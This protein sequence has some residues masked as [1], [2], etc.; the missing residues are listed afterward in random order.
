MATIENNRGG[1]DDA[2]FSYS[3]RG[4]G[5]VFISW[6]GRQVKILRGNKAVSFLH[7]VAGL[8]SSDQQ[9]AMAK[10][11]GNFKRGNEHK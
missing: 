2:P 1:L 3:D 11:T 6:R 9:L 7:R 4:N 8:D 10:V 5:K